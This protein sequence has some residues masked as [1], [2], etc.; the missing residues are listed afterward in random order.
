M[1]HFLG[2]FR[3][4][5]IKSSFVDS[6]KYGVHFE[7]SRVVLFKGNTYDAN[8]PDNEEYLL[9]GNTLSPITLTGGGSDV[10]FERLNGKTNQ[11]GTV[12]ISSVSDPSR[13]KVITIRGTGIVEFD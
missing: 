13:S 11:S 6:S 12:T 8:D 7:A 4:V 5:T 10:V 2:L 3:A 1:I 9:R